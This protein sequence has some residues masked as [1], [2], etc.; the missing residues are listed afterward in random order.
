[1]KNEKLILETLKVLLMKVDELYAYGDYDTKEKL[2][3]II[4]TLNDLN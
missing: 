4:A 3:E 1:M 2:L